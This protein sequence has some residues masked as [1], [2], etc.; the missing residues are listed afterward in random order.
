MHHPLL[1]ATIELGDGK[2]VVVTG[3]FSLDDQPWLADH[4]LSGTPLLPGTAFL[5]LALTAGQKAGCHR[6]DELF[7]ESPLV[8]P[9]SGTVAVHFVIGR[10]DQ[11]GR[12]AIDMYARVP[13]GTDDQAWVRHA[14]GVLGTG[15]VPPPPSVRAPEWPPA[16]ATP[17]DLAGAYTRLAERGYEHG[18]A[19]QGL[20]AA[21]RHGDDLYA[22][23]VLPGDTGTGYTI[24]PALLDAALHPIA[25]GEPDGDDRPVPFSWHGVRVYAAGASTLRVRL[26]RAGDGFRIHLSDPDGVPVATVDSLRLRAL[27]AAVV[28]GLSTA[29]AP[30]ALAWPVLAGPVD[31]PSGTTAVLGELP[32]VAGKR[33]P[34]L[35]ALGRELSSG[36]PAPG[37]V[38]VPVA[39]QADTDLPDAVG[40]AV[41]SVL[42]TVRQWLSDDRLAPSRLAF[43]THGAVAVERGAPVADLG[44]A[45]VWGL[46]RSV[47]SEN[48]GRF[49]VVDVD[50]TPASYARLTAAPVAGEPQLALREGVV[51]VP[52]LSPAQPSGVTP[53]LDPEGTVLIT[54][55]TGSLGGLV[56]KHLVARYGARRLLLLSRSGPAAPAAERLRA[57]LTD[58][59]A[60]VVIHACDV[61]EF[62]A[63]AA[64]L[65]ALPPEHPLTAVVHSAG[66]LDDA[67]VTALTFGRLGKVLA[68]KADAAWHLH[69]LTRDR[70]LAAFVLFSSVAGTAGSA[71]QAGY[72][73]ANAFLDALA[74]ARWAQ[75][76]PATSMAW[77]WWDE[78]GGMAAS[79]SD[80]DRRRMTGN[81]IRPLSTEDGLALFDAALTSDAPA[82]VT[83]RL[84]RAALRRLAGADEL[85]A[86]FR[87]LVPAG[88]RQAGTGRR[89]GS[90]LAGRLA[91]LA[92]S[93]RRDQVL[94]L[95][96]STV[97]AVLDY[98]GAEQIDPAQ[99]FK[100]LGLDSL[101]AVE[102][103]N[104]LAAAAG[105]PLPA[106]LAF[107]H[108]SPAALAS[109]LLTEILDGVAA[110]VVP[111]SAAVSNAE[112]IAVV[113]MACRYPGGVR[114][115][116]DL[117][118]LVEAGT[119]A[120]GLF[121][122]NRG[123]PTDTIYDP[124]PDRPGT[125]Y[126][127]H[128]G[129][130]YDAG[131]FDAAF[132][133]MSPREAL[134]TDPQQRLLLEVAWEAIESAG[135][136]PATL[137]GS[138]TGV[139]AGI[140]YH[141]YATLSH[142]AQLEGLVGTGT[143]G[144]VASG[145]V[146]FSFGLHGPAITVDTACSSSLV[147]VH[148]AGQALRAG[149]CSLA[150]AG[151][152]TVMATPS[153][154]IEFSR[155]RGLAPDGRCK[156]F[157]ARA[158]GTG[159]SEG[160]GIL[161]LERLSDAQR[162]GHPILAVI[163]GTAVNQ[164]GASNG[165]TAPN[166]PAQERVIRQALA[167]AQLSPTD[168]DAVE[169]HGTGTTLG[170]PIEA[171]AL[172]A[173]Y[174]QD[175]DRP[176]WLGS[177]KSNIGHTQAAAGIAGIIKMIQAMH[178][179]T[180]PKTLHADEPT[181]HIDWATGT[182]SLLTEN[183]PWPEGGA[184]RAGVSSFGISGTNAHVILEQAPPE[185]DHPPAD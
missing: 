55:G 123:W 164:D 23:V 165:L 24:H 139:Y 68:P 168:I 87:G 43:V 36:A 159:W 141:D 103:R 9:R 158:D 133:D 59:G 138:D 140:M 73:A 30:L 38:F 137:H 32:G 21:W 147:A 160:A 173:T 53:E 177:I 86:V 18:P 45:A 163:R 132:F 135:I 136:D 2:G 128:G 101:T 162:N 85:P 181:P 95:I 142:P 179:A 166:G 184:R 170:D 33:H 182:V 175:R 155:Q 49:A 129:F 104:R 111:V 90:T 110:P 47:Q 178:H 145:R 105:M 169:A 71:G 118:D 77:G 1:G 108:P 115:P 97:A 116:D 34:D 100:E 50:G 12:R 15:D 63:L 154:F 174:G 149:E 57:E 65:D 124:D 20:T 54:G 74:A 81:G 180:L 112:P 48:P 134:A 13:D 44:A 150:L 120:I 146:A 52:R 171:Q 6:L 60:E 72:A 26:V 42:D 102:L 127:R 17:L 3:G 70:P 143:A 14:H 4:A 109:F 7:L 144:S 117:W 131:D 152:A 64:E 78:A 37:T 27:P 183:S 29:P 96:R 172:L 130:L 41:R 39:G 79:L 22:E 40:V 99:S 35:A 16:G 122:E 19:F 61:T 119:D 92:E 157:G 106:S 82:V 66:V 80:I 76:L 46:L 121:P 98:P 8:I 67:T 176:L 5:E 69:R 62:G 156:S 83:A 148:M 31:P 11:N 167:N 75:G 161:L 113:G 91:G 107:D 153:V 84:D 126:T 51:H 89:A 151:G 125:T 94:R 185:E 28:R 10:E 93:E 88:P 25:F 56:A 114:S 58:L